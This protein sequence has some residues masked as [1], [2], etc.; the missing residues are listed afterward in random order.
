ME[1]QGS[2]L[3]VDDNRSVLV[4]AKMLLENYF[5]SV[6]TTSIPDRIRSILQEN[7]IGVI[8]LDMNFKAGINNG[9]EGLFW[10]GSRNIIPPC[11][12]YFLPLMR[13]LSWP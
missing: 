7:E 9:N 2:I 1:K 12:S 3:I 4:A 11:R 10:L 13:I 8:L 5:E 6:I